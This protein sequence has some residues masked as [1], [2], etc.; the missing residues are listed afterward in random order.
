MRL[1]LLP[2][3]S[4]RICLK[5][6]WERI[7]GWLVCSREGLELNWLRSKV[8]V[9]EETVLLVLVGVRLIPLCGW[10]WWGVFHGKLPLSALNKKYFFYDT[11][12]GCSWLWVRVFLFNFRLICSLFH[13]WNRVYLSYRNLWFSWLLRLAV[14]KLLVNFWVRGFSYAWWGDWCCH[15]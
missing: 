6:S 2:K 14:W 9:C 13:L 7:W 11:S 3:F 1:I 4:C 8:V 12:V 10:C 15:L 5:I